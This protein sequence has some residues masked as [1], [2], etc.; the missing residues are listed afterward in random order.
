L[1][2][3]LCHT[4]KQTLIMKALD[5]QR[6]LNLS[7]NLQLIHILQLRVFSPCVINIL[8]SFNRVHGPRIGISTSGRSER[9]NPNLRGPATPAI[10]HGDGGTSDLKPTC[11]HNIRKFG[12]MMMNLHRRS[13]PSSDRK[14]GSANPLRFLNLNTSRARNLNGARSLNT[15]LVAADV[16]PRLIVNLERDPQFGVPPSGG[17]EKPLP[18][19]VIDTRHLVTGSNP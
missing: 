5:P 4:G 13:L 19:L 3:P 17:P 14:A 8:H 10:A 7:T 11:T 15:G 2:Y 6:V 9:R 12:E 16:S 18:P 1:S